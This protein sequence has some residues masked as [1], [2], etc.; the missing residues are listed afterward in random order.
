MAALAGVAFRVLG[1]TASVDARWNTQTHTEDSHCPGV[2]RVED[3]P[4][5][6]YQGK[7][8]ADSYE[9][10]Y[11]G[12]WDSQE[13]RDENGST[14]TSPSFQVHTGS[15]S[16]GRKDQDHYLGPLRGSRVCVAASQVSEVA[17]CTHRA[18]ESALTDFAPCRRC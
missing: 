6:Y 11:E 4:V 8:V 14:F 13:P 15:R 18:L 5:F 2:D 3:V 16:D 17:N 10:L 1:S 7:K 12:N 9:E